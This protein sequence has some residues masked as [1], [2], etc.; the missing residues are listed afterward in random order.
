MLLLLLACKPTKDATDTPLGDSGLDSAPC[1]P[2]SQ[3]IDADEDGYG[4]GTQPAEGCPGEVGLSEQAGDCDDGDASVHPSADE[5]C[6]GADDDCD[7]LVDGADD[8]LVG[9]SALYEDRDGD[10]FGDAGRPITGCEGDGVEDDADCDDDDATR[11]PGA[12]WYVDRDEDGYGDPASEVIRCEPPPQHQA[13]GTDCDDDDATVNPGATEVCDGADTDCDPATSEAG[14]ARFVS[15]GGAVVTMTSALK[16]GSTTPKRAELTTD[17]TLS[18][19][20]GT[21]YSELIVDADVAIEGHGAV[22]LDGADRVPLVQIEPGHDVAL[23][24]LTLTHGDGTQGGAVAC[25]G[26]SISMTDV[27]AVDNQA[28]T[29]SALYADGCDVV[30]DGVTL[31]DNEATYGTLYVYD[32]DLDATDVRV[33]D[34]QA[35]IYTLYVAGTGSSGRAQV[36]L[37]EVEIS[38]NDLTNYVHAFFSYADVVWS[39]SSATGSGL[40]A[41]TSGSTNFGAMYLSQATVDAREV[42]L[43]EGADDNASDDIFVSNGVR[44]RAGDDATFTCDATGCGSST[45]HSLGGTDSTLTY[46]SYV[47]GALV[48]ADTTATIDTLSLYASGSGCD[49][50]YYL[51]SSATGSGTWTLEWSDSQSL[52]SS[53]SWHDSDAVGIPVEDGRMYIAAAGWT[54][55][56]DVRL[57]TSGLSSDAGFGTVTGYAYKSGQTSSL[58]GDTTFTT[59]TSY[60][61]PWR[62]RIAVTEL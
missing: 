24:G 40:T 44:Y 15:D 36:D 58:T 1:V 23:S 41:N 2:T 35:S 19:C 29:G 57:A 32:G 46:T 34:N 28:S 33:Q 21:W 45:K 13:D 20:E 16:G 27:D 12:T 11:F 37:D 14:S 62:L 6:N 4:D 9:G 61:M 60:T 39:G 31:T 42:D 48:E 51:Y 59:S 25:D 7:G 26:S 52:S 56:I 8:S 38:E 53:A 30:L 5:T 49:I 47:V 10:G 3:W 18:I 50:D 43:G 54:C 22:T 17:G 55:S